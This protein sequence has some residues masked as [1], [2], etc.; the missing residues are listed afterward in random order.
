M[1]T[2]IAK[3]NSYT[4]QNYIYMYFKLPKEQLWHYYNSQLKKFEERIVPTF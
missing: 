3:I 2:Q 4:T 1:P